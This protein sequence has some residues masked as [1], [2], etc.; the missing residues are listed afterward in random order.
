MRLSSLIAIAMAVTVLSGCGLVKKV[1]GKDNPNLHWKDLPVPIYASHEIADDS[2]R[3]ADLQAAMEYWENKAGQKIFDYRGAYDRALPPIDGPIDNPSA[4]HDNVIFFTNDWRWGSEVAGK[5][6]LLNDDAEIAGA[7]L[8]INKNL[9]YCNGSCSGNSGSSVPFRRLLAHELGHVIGLDHSPEGENIMFA[10]LKNDGNIS[11][12]PCD[13]D[14]LK[15]A[16][17]N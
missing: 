14:A 6:I 9:S 13:M 17:D 7:M 12:A 4:I 10:N 11:N 1:L 15:A 3:S 5:T 8:L 16:L 2:Q